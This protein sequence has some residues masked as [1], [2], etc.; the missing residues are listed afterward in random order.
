MNATD[1]EL[2]L[3]SESCERWGWL[4]GGIIVAGVVAEVVIAA[5]ESA[6]QLI[7]GTVG[8][9][10]GRCPCSVRRWRR[11]YVCPDWIFATEGTLATFG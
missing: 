2:E 10:R 9:H 6:I 1:C 11:N 7:L 8:D 5:V 3:S 4:C